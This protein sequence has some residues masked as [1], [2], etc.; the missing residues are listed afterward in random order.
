MADLAQLN[1]KHKRACA[2]VQA[3]LQARGAVPIE[4]P[5]LA[6]FGPGY[7]SGWKVVQTFSGDKKLALAVLVTDGFPISPP[8]LALFDPPPLLTWPHV[9]EKGLICVFQNAL[10]YD[11]NQ[12]E[13]VVAELLEQGIQLLQSNVDG[14]VG[15]EFRRE[16]VSYWNRDVA[17]AEIHTWSLLAPERRHRRIH[18][19]SDKRMRIVA[20]DEASLRRWLTH[21]EVPFGGKGIGRGALIWLDVPLVPAEYPAS[22]A[23]L[24]RLVQHDAEAVQVLGDLFADGGREA[25]IVLGVHTSSG[26]GLGGIR[27][28]PPKLQGAPG[29]RVDP[30]AKGFRPKHIPARI[31]AQRALSP[32]MDAPKVQVDRI[33]HS[34]IHGRDSD[35]RQA[36]L[37]NS[38]VVLVGVGSLGSTVAKLLARA[39]VGNLTL[40][41]HDTLKWENLGRHE[42]GSAYVGSPKSLSLAAEISA[43]LPHLSVQGVAS[44]LQPNSPAWDVCSEADLIISTTGD[45]Q[46]EGL[47]N[48]L[49]QNGEIPPVLFAWLEAHAAAAHSVLVKERGVCLRCGIGAAGQVYRPVSVWPNEGLVQTPACGG[50][51]SPYGA[52]ELAYAHA[53]V[54]EHAL[55]QL[56]GQEENAAY[57]VW[58]GRTARWADGGGEVSEGW[59]TAYGNPEDGGR[60]L[61]PDWPHDPHCPVCKRRAVA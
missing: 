8:R 22:A 13:A 2:R 36:T 16:F 10:S 57:R 6:M 49:Q 50:V 55:D 29:R 3:F 17:D 47:L 38:K 35:A 34:W 31:A 51:F 61:Q 46:I 5:E 7:T 41:D 30:V 53:L 9:E 43:A 25:D 24:Y 52:A 20:D 40:I 28:H 32:A 58:I 60:V 1:R 42:L 18:V 33:D 44:K 39:G 21:S 56:L 15:A 14:N 11:I 59:S 37:Q 23:D 26:I 4:G 45:W 19:W 27:V 48:E 12:P 54:S